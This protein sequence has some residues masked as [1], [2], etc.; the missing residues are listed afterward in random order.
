[1]RAQIFERFARID[2]GRS[3]DRGGTGLGLAIAS[4]IVTSHG[5]TISL[6]D[7]PVGARLIVRL[8]AEE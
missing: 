7:A 8:P 6:G 3:R 4:E 1:M 2:E 5:G